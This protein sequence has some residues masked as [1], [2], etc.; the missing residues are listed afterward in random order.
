MVAAWYLS[1]IS[2]RKRLYPIL[3]SA[4][5]KRNTLFLSERTGYRHTLLKSPALFVNRADFSAYDAFFSLLMQRAK[6]RSMIK[7]VRRSEMNVC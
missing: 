6:E 7:E 5:Q 1:S 2:T 4:R 3:I